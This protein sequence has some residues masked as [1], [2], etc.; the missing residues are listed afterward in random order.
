MRV[1]QFAGWGI[2]DHH[3][4]CYDCRHQHLIPKGEQVSMQPWFDWDHKHK[5]HKTGIFPTKL[6]GKIEDSWEWES[7]IHNANVKGVYVASSSIT[8][9]L[10]SLATSSTLVAGRESAAVTNAS[11]LYLDDLV[12]FKITVGT[13]PTANTAI[14]CHAIGAMNDTPTWPDVFAGA[15]AARTVT[16]VQV[17]AGY[18]I[19]VANFVVVATTSNVAYS[20]APVGIRRFFGD[21]LPVQYSFFVTH[22]TVAALNSTG[23]N[24]VISHTPVYQTVT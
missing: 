7:F 11:N 20:S 8:C 23:G 24:H 6:M 19:P 18:V 10:A 4:V 1:E 21:L 17:K 9:T 12:A 22:S 3:A 16:N 15:D 2:T 13:T 5:G 14:E